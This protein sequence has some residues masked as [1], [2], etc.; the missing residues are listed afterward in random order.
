MRHF[1]IGFPI[2]IVVFAVTFQPTGAEVQPSGTEPQSTIIGDDDLPNGAPVQSTAARV[3]AVCYYGPANVELRCI[4][5]TIPE[6][7]AA[8]R[9]KRLHEGKRGRVQCVKNPAPQQERARPASLKVDSAAPD[10]SASR[11][12]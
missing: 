11:A 7:R 5:D 1:L 4:F 10:P 9:T 8:C 6:C 3:K 12:H 2:L